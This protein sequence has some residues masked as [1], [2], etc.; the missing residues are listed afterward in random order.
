M[1]FSS[2]RAE[3]RCAAVLSS[4]GI[5]LP[6]AGTSEGVEEFVGCEKRGGKEKGSELRRELYAP[7]A[8]CL[9]A[10]LEADTV[11]GRLFCEVTEDTEGGRG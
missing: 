6:S 8:V 9:G 1:L 4:R 10:L 7:F 5:G 2:R 11:A 3:V